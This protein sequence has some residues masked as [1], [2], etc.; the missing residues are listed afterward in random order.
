[1]Y[2][3]MLKVTYL[4]ISG[5]FIVDVVQPKFTW[6]PFVSADVCVKWRRSGLIDHCLRS[7]AMVITEKF[8]F[9]TIL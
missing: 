5:L 1:M 6:Q 9:S 8:I 3:H 2:S 4:L 7:A